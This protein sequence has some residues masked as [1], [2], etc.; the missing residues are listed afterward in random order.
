MSHSAC[1]FHVSRCFLL[2]NRL[3]L[4]NLLQVPRSLDL[5][6]GRGADRGR[7]D[8]PASSHLVG[9]CLV[10]YRT[11][12]HRGMSMAEAG[13][14]VVFS[15]PG[16]SLYFSCSFEARVLA[17][18]PQI[19]PPG[20]HMDPGSRQELSLGLFPD[21]LR[22]GPLLRNEENCPKADVVAENRDPHSAD[23][24]SRSIRSIGPC[25]ILIGRF[26]RPRRRTREAM[27]PSAP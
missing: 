8:R 17:L 11:D 13:C 27:P 18:M 25:F 24:P 23:I 10:F 21:P 6:F 20:L 2:L 15:V 12:L 7:Q 3:W 1:V 22:S 14:L 4:R 19:L 16:V 26:W 9:P 5:V